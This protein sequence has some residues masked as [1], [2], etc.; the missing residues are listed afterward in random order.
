[1][2]HTQ[3]FRASKE[4]ASSKIACSTISK[5]LNR[6]DFF[7]LKNETG[8]GRLLPSILHVFKNVQVH[9]KIND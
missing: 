2:C 5:P 1:M 9:M 4:T 6:N 3:C 7:I 8:L